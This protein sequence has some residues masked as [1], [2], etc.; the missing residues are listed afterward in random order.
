MQIKT[1]VIIWSD[2][3]TYICWVCSKISEIFIYSVLL[4]KTTE[5]CYLTEFEDHTLTIKF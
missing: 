1:E 5:I 2:M 3:I 4:G